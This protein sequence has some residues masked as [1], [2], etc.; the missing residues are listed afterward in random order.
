MATRQS[1]ATDSI[2]RASRII[3]TGLIAVPVGSRRWAAVIDHDALAYAAGRL[4]GSA[5]YRTGYWCD[6]AADGGW[7]VSRRSA[8]RAVAMCARPAT[9]SSLRTLAAEAQS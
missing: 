1:P 7:G 2:R 3:R 9:Y 8:E 5:G 4:P 6:D